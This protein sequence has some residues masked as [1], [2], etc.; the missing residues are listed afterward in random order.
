MIYEAVFIDDVM[1]MMKNLLE[2][3]NGM[4]PTVGEVINIH[5]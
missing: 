5:L 1:K 4:F 2:V 3:C